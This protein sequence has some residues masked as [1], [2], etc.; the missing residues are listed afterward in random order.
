MH[1]WKT[2]H[3][4]EP[5]FLKYQQQNLFFSFL[6]LFSYFDIFFI[7]QLWYKMSPWKRAQPNKLKTHKF[8]FVKK[9]IS[10]SILLWKI[11]TR[12][13]FCGCRSLLLLA[14]FYNL[15]KTNVWQS[16]LCGAINLAADR[17][18]LLNYATLWKVQGINLCPWNM[19][20]CQPDQDIA[21]CAKRYSS[22]FGFNNFL[23]FIL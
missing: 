15:P 4:F 8:Y 22:I 16:A 23:P 18:Y 20:N 13:R 6:F 7:F 14:H 3:A 9:I 1:F 12:G 17:K 2:V 10:P 11:F 21:W 5:L 19:L